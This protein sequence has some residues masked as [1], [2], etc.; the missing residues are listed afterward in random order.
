MF[1]LNI[2]EK[3]FWDI[4]LH[5]FDTNRNKRI[6]IERVFSMGDLSDIKEVIHFYGLEI[7]KREITKAGYLDNKTLTW[8]SNF[9][10][11]SKT[12]FKCFTKKQ[13]NQVHWNY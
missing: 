5:N 9:L 13:S 1:S 10:N 7:I 11:I 8:I 12:K 4:D 3:L 6:I 2:S